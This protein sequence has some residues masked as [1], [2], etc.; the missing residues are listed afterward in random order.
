MAD[1]ESAVALDPT[2]GGWHH[3]LGR[4]RQRRRD[5]VGAAAAIETAVAQDPTRG[6]WLFH[7]GQARENCW[8]LAAAADAYA[9]AVTLTPERGAW[10]QRLEQVRRAAEVFRPYT[11]VIVAHRGR[12]GG[13]AENTIESLDHLPAHVSGVEVDVRLTRDGVPV[14]M[15]DPSLERTTGGQGMVTE[16]RQAQVRGLRGRDGAPVPRLADY[17]G[18]CAGRGFQRVL[19]DVKAPDPDAF[20]VVSEVIGASPV[21]SQCVVMARTDT[22]MAQLR[23]VTSD[24]RLGGLQVTVDNC[25]ERIAAAK[26][27]GAEMLFVAHGGRRYLHHR[28][29]V[30]AIREAGILAG[31]ST[32]NGRGS[33]EA[34]RID[35]CDLI[36]T[37]LAD[38]L[39]HFAGAAGR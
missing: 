25:R 15:H 20:A 18:A 10:A 30:A 33:L 6:L 3:R 34:A 23:Q 14:L 36:L 9:A 29:A 1:L 12:S 19:V 11:G 22:A 38:Q 32:V 13:R 37:D 28:Q 24:V 26:R 35:G 31:A 2:R 5:W 39:R 16:L 21:A 27:W 17:L 8:D 7:L 4:L